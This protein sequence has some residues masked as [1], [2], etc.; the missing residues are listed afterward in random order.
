MEPKY[1]HL[2]QDRDVKRWYDNVARGSL[3]TADVYLRRLGNFCSAHNMN[4]R[5]LLSMRDENLQNLLFD[6]VTSMEKDYAGSYIESVIKVIRSWLT[7]NGKELKV[8]IKI[9]GANDTPSLKDERVPTKEE[10]KKILLS[11]DKKTRAACILVAHSGLRIETL[12][13]Y[14]GLDGLRVKDFPEIIIDNEADK[15][16][17]AKVPTMIVV[18]KELSKAKHQYFTFLSEEGCE[19]IKDYLEEKLR[20][21]EELVILLFR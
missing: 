19:Y 1:V 17:F 11:C 7:F 16:S 3:A 5:D 21:G 8:K 12:G 18:R 6:Y 13:N 15:V 10:L 2:L 4:P 9:K 20:S 14:N